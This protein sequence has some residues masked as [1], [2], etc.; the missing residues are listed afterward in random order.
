ML[1]RN[2][3]WSVALVVL[4]VTGCAS[5]PADWGRQDAA[6]RVA[7]RGRPSTMSADA[8]TLVPRLLGAPL[9]ADSAVQLALMNNPDLRR[10]ASQLGIAAAE[11]YDAGRLANPSFSLTRLAG[12]SSA[13]ANVPQ[14]TLGIAFNFVNLLFLPANTRFAAAQFESAKLEFGAAAMDLA[15]DVEAAWYEAVGAEQLAR[16]REAAR[17]AQGASAALAQRY[18][19]AGNI[20]ARALA[21]ERSAASQA[22][23]A[24]ISARAASVEARIRLNRLMGLPADPQRWT[25]AARLAEPLAVDE[26][27]AGLTRLALES[28][29]D[30]IALRRR[31]QAL[32]DRFGITRA[33]RWVNGVEI[34]V[35]RERDFDGALD[36]GPTLSL[37][38]PLF[39]WGGGRVAAIHAAFDRAEAD[40]DARVLDVSNDVAAAA[41]RASARRDL[42]HEYRDALVP[43]REAIVARMQEEQNYMLI[44]VFEVLAAKQQAYEAYSG[45]IEAVR[46]YWVARSH[47]TRV[48]GRRLPSSDVPAEPTI[49]ADSIVRPQAAEG[50]HA[51]HSMHDGSGMDPDAHENTPSSDDPNSGDPTHDH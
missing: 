42:A 15:A 50:H 5:V 36:V 45:Y 18:F 25:L 46:D 11:L 32:S 3:P 29:L 31:S 4:G 13:G 39:N 6:A 33:T 9:T 34:G 1:S 35:E 7:E 26:D 14:L 24:A 16:M 10:H 51:D 27:V 23:L 49:D 20:S 44:G 41:S 19:E 21:M 12:D 8:P 48:V 40:L 37:E 30:V 47:L 38:L 22:T 2:F 28:R 17:Q 43:Q